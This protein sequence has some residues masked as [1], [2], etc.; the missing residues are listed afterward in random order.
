MEER[1]KEKKA[2]TTSLYTFI[3]SQV[4]LCSFFLSF[5]LQSKK[6]VFEGWH[7]ISSEEA[8]FNKKIARFRSAHFRPLEQLAFK[9]WADLVDVK[10]Q[11]EEICTE[12]FQAYRL[13]MK[14][15]SFT[16]WVNTAAGQ[17]R[18]DGTVR[19]NTNRFFTRRR[20]SQAFSTWHEEISFNHTAS[21]KI[22]RLQLR[23]TMG[24][25]KRWCD[26]T[27]ERHGI[28]EEMRALKQRRLLRSIV[29]SWQDTIK[30]GICKKRVVSS[31]SKKAD[32]RCIERALAHW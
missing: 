1:G 30:Q 8:V 7:A 3:H 6:K 24:S 17:E 22:C 9:K 19:V 10:R 28:A 21:R 18:V 32:M 25:W 29:E 20:L 23:K 5:V 2:F 13:K 14:R 27:K 26:L 12:R 16:S 11:Q 4:L 15:T 31:L